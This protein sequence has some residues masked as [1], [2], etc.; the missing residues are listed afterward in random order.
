M[1]Q[2]PPDGEWLVQTIGTDTVIFHRYTEEEI[3]RVPS[4]DGNANALA[5]KAIHFDN[6]LT[7]EQ[8][9]FA[10]FWMGYFYAYASGGDRL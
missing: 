1:A 4:A 10:H 3:V 9:A 8:K 5:Q 6:R 7:E 2:L